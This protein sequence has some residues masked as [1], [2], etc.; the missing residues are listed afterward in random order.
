MSRLTCHVL[1]ATAGRPAPGVAVTV[2]RISGGDGAEVLVETAT[3]ADGRALLV[4]DGPGPGRYEVAFAVGDHFGLDP[5][6]RY[7]D[8]V[9]IHIGVPAGDDV[10][11]HVALLVTPWSYTTYRGS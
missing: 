6:E 2:R 3:D 9:P 11:V 1:D 4:A 8:V 5:A 7:L 10:H